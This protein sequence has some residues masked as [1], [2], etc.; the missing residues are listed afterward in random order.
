MDLYESLWKVREEQHDREVHVENKEYGLRD[1]SC[2]ICNKVGTRRIGREFSEFWRAVQNIRQIGAIKFNQRTI[3]AFYQ[4][5]GIMKREIGEEIIELNNYEGKAK[6]IRKK[7]P[8]ETY[9]KGFEKM[10]GTIRYGKGLKIRKIEYLI[11]IIF[12]II[13]GA[14]WIEEIQNEEKA[15]KVLEM[16]EEREYGY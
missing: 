5:Q 10:L 4:I 3:D 16:M 2:T 6:E 13:I 12:M 11:E 15:E 8:M 14:I 7:F 1:P 9:R